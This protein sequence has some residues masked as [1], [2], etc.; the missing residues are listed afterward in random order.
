MSKTKEIRQ[1]LDQLYSLTPA[2]RG[3]IEEQSEKLPPQ[4]V[5]EILAI[6]R[7][8]VAHQDTMLRERIAKDPSFPAQLEAFLRQNLQSIK[9]VAERIERASTD[10]QFGQLS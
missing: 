5:A 3:R 1:L 6:L 7:Q 10:R 9:P 4:A 8:A 2:E